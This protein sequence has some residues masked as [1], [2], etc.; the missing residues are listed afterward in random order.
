MI[1]YM[2]KRKH[3]GFY[4]ATFDSVHHRSPYSAID[5]FSIREIQPVR[6]RYEQDRHALQ[7][8]LF[9]RGLALGFDD[10]GIQI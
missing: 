3:G 2:E 1:I 10:M 6:T 8:K 9:K 7:G 5:F 4:N